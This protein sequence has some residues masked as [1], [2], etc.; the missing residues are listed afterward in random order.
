[1]A[2]GLPRRNTVK[3]ILRSSCYEV[4]EPW[5]LAL[6]TKTWHT[7]LANIKLPFLEEIAFGGSIRLKKCKTTKDGLVPSA[8]SIKLEREYEM[9]RL[10]NLKRQ[11]NAAEEIRFSLREKK[12]GLRRPLPPK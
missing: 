6:L 3:T 8:E 10:D 11:E 7:N 12:I 2:Y 4:Q 1:M 5:E 9:K